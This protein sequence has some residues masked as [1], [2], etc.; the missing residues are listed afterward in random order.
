MK[1]SDSH[2]KTLVSYLT[3]P[4]LVVATLST[5][6]FFVKGGANPV[7][8]MAP[9]SLITFLLVT[10][11]EVK[12]PQRADWG[13]T[14]HQLSVDGMH[15]IFTELVNQFVFRQLYLIILGALGYTLAAN[16]I[17]VGVWSRL[18]VAGLHPVLQVFIGLYCL[19]FLLYWQ[20]RSM[21]EIDWL[22][23]FHAVHHSPDGMSTL[24]AIRNH[25]IG[26]ITTSFLT[27]VFSF[28]CM[29]KEIYF[30]VLSFIVIKG[31]L[32]HANVELKTGILDYFF[33]T[34]NNH[35]WHHSTDMRPGNSNFGLISPFWDYMP[36]HRVPVLGR[37]LKFKRRTFYQNEIRKLPLQVGIKNL[38]IN[39]AQSG[40]EVWKEQNL[41]PFRKSEV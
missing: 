1:Q 23:K 30:T 8:V 39:T 11:I 31:W 12:F 15:F 38:K 21:H 35:R 40:F 33:M 18:G 3:W 2:V 41:A 17:T 19:D 32:Q 24:N 5:V 25:L 4:V 9:V 22:W 7:A 34:P 10:M 14:R 28:L 6:Y 29:P 36:W 13:P 20:H 16:F 26:P 27:L 37:M